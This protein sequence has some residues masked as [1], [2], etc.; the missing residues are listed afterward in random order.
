M[1]PHPLVFVVLPAHT[2]P[3]SLVPTTT[4]TYP[5][6]LLTHSPTHSLTHSHLLPQVT[7]FTNALAKFEMVELS[8]TGKIALKRGEDLLETGSTAAKD[9]MPGQVGSW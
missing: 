5:L 1:Y 2:P 6:A 7:A 8:R 3:S 4:T 9:M